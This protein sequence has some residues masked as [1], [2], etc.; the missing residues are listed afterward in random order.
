M[1]SVINERANAQ[2]K[3]NGHERILDVG[4]GLAQFTRSMARAT[5]DGPPV[6][7]IERDAHQLE[8]AHRLAE[9]DGESDT[10]E[11]RQGDA[12]SLP[13]S[14][15]EWATF[16]IVHSRFLLEH[17]PNPLA[18]VQQMARA[19]KPDGR[20]ILQDDDHDVMRFWP[21]LD[22]LSRAWHAY[23]QSYQSRGT[24]GYIGRK[25]PQV[26]HHAGLVP[27]HT[28]WL[29]YGACA[30]S[31]LFEPLLTNLQGVLV[32]AKSATIAASDITAD[33][34]DRGIDSLRQWRLLPDAAFWYAICWAE[35]R[36]TAAER[37]RTSTP[38]GN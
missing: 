6:V 9:Q 13:L 16:D 2:M 3:L 18:A 5:P 31:P 32:G 10:I 34:F 37:T 7:G 11:L 22:E 17:L 15:E 1:N 35:A 28:T 21:P 24:D 25:L 19:V 8:E 23:A 38:V 4:S 36:P 27:T 26:L 20:V 33:L 29:F 30:G 12:T 14:T